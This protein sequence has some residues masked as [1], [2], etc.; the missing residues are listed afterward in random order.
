MFFIT[1]FFLIIDVF[2]LLLELTLEFTS[3]S[4]TMFLLQVLCGCFYSSS[5]GKTSYLWICTTD[6]Y[7]GS[8]ISVLSIT[9]ATYMK[10]V[11]TLDLPDIRVTALEVVR[12]SD[13]VWMGT[14][15]QK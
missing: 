14:N 4:F 12:A 1:I 9:G 6:N 2:H 8:H 13:T 3:N 10:Q 11:T 7:A 5:C 15:S